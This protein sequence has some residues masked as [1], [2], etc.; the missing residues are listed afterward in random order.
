MHAAMGRGHD[1]VQ[2]L[3]RQD[4]RLDGGRM[5]VSIQADTGRGSGPECEA[6]LE[7][8]HGGGEHRVIEDERDQFLLCRCFP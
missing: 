4:C 3:E 2:L 8:G 6:H 5:S 7:L 1:A